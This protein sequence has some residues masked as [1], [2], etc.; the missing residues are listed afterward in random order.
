MSIMNT[1]E[2]AAQFLSTLKDADES[3]LADVFQALERGMPLFNSRKLSEPKVK[4]EKKVK[5]K[6]EETD[7]PEASSGAPDASAYRMPPAS[8]DISICVARITKDGEDKRWAPAVYRERQC[9]KD[10]TE[11]GLCKTCSARAEKYEGKAGAWLG[12]VTEEPLEWVH[13]LGTEWAAK[14]KPVFKDAGAD[15]GADA[16]SVGNGSQEIEMPEKVPEKVAEKVAEVEAKV[17]KVAKTKVA[18]AKANVSEDKAAAKAAKEAEKAAAKAA[19]EAEK[20]AAKAAKEAEKAEKTK[21]K[22]EKAEKKPKAKKAEVKV[23][24][25]EVKAVEAE[26]VEVTGEMRIIEDVVYFIRNGNVYNY[27]E[28]DEEIGNFVGRLKE[29]TIDTEADEIT[30]PESE[31][32]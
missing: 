31:S 15:A 22:A 24:E 23:T 18:K 20:E 25:T 19:K 7:L 5:E 1:N 12:R 14:K 11:N 6:K 10:V 21:A 17:A 32:E 13:M 4:K 26:V 9:G 16:E 3:Y 28:L 30:A 2:F 8:I 27:S 29:G